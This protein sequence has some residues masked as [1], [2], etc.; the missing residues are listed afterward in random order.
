[1]G[2]DLEHAKLIVPEKLTQP[3]IETHHDKD[4]AGHQGVKRTRDLV[5]LNYFWPSRNQ[6]IEN[7]VKQYD[8]GTRLII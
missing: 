5:K 6:D 3:I 7:Y 1:M 2:S 8:K 4:F